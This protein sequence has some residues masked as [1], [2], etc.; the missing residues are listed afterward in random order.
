MIVATYS[1]FDSEAGEFVVKRLKY[2][3]M[4]QYLY[5]NYGLS[6]NVCD[7]AKHK[8]MI[9]GRYQILVDGSEEVRFEKQKQDGFP[10]VLLNE[11]DRIRLLVN[12]LAKRC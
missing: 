1:L 12:P 2:G 4:E 5:D 3:E 11:W 8:R 10:T 7:Y 6:K 9:K